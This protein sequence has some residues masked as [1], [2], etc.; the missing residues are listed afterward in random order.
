[1]WLILLGGGAANCGK[2]RL[3]RPCLE[4]APNKLRFSF[5]YLT[6]KLKRIGQL[7]VIDFD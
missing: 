7:I 1:M 2:C 3:E 4:A 5:K 6:V